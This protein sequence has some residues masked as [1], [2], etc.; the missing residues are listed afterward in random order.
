ME[1]Q[2][3]RRVAVASLAVEDGKAI[4]AYGSV[5]NW[6]MHAAYIL[7]ISRIVTLNSTAPQKHF[8]TYLEWL[9][10]TYSVSTLGSFSVTILS[11]CTRRTRPSGHDAL[12]RRTGGNGPEP[13]ML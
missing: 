10:T 2:K 9:F 6:V 11:A 8:P 5:G 4:G 12:N 1:E 13:G 7:L 3:H